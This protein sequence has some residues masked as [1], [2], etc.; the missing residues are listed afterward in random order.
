MEANHNH[1]K[2]RETVNAIYVVTGF[3]FNTVALV[4]TNLRSAAKYAFN[5]FSISCWENEKLSW[6][7]SE[8]HKSTI[9]DEVLKIL[10]QYYKE[11]KKG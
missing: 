1:M 6:V 4:T 9:P 3:P 5:T 2:E 10:K 11:N 8:I 7:Y